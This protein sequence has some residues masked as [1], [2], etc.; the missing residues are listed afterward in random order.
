[1]GKQTPAKGE[2]VSSNLGF[3]LKDVW[4]IGEGQFVKKIEK[5]GAPTYMVDLIKG[6]KH[7]GRRVLGKQIIAVAE[8]SG[9]IDR[10]RPNV[11]IDDIF[12]NYPPLA[13]ALEKGL[14][15]VSDVESGIRKLNYLQENDHF[16]DMTCLLPRE[17]RVD[18]YTA[19]VNYSD[20]MPI[21]RAFFQQRERPTKDEKNEVERNGKMWKNLAGYFKY[22]RSIIAGINDI[23]DA[24]SIL[25]KDKT[26]IPLRFSSEE[27]YIRVEDPSID[28]GGN[29]RLW[30]HVNVQA[31][32]LFVKDENGSRVVVLYYLGKKWK[33]DSWPVVYSYIEKLRESISVGVQVEAKG[34]AFATPAGSVDGNSH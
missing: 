2:R 3:D 24:M 19:S 20:R 14:I 15:T 27:Y 23:N 28:I 12:R 26:I 5:A 25:G 30:D 6:I 22:D 17:I 11:T 4:R 32:S 9:K 7:A 21:K 16:V 1:M 8:Y 10:E 31:A 34:R 29:K 33:G 18:G 13:E